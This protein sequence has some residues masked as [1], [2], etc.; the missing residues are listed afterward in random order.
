M[1]PGFWWGLLVAVLASLLI[2]ALYDPE[3]PVRFI[4]GFLLGFSCTHVGREMWEDRA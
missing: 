3:Q 2:F 4:V 1:N